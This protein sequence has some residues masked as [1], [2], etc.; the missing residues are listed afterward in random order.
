MLMN[1]NT[2]KK[3]IASERKIH[4]WI[5]IIENETVVLVWTIKVFHSSLE[6]ESGKAFFIGFDDVPLSCVHDY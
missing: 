3:D 6:I 5:F 2:Q 4:S 1:Q